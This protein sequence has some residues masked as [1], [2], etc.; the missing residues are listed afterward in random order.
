MSIY[1]ALAHFFGQWL[2][3]WV[4]KVIDETL[5]CQLL[6]VWTHIVAEVVS[7]CSS[8]GVLNIIPAVLNGM[9]VVTEQDEQIIAFGFP[10][11]QPRTKAPEQ[12]WWRDI[13][14]Y[15]HLEVFLIAHK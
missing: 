3:T 6:A 10:A 7:E 12:P 14:H 11:L 2:E 5:L 8:N 13:D 1:A 4:T 15:Y 9:A